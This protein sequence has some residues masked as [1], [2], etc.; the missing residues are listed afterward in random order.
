[1]TIKIPGIFLKKTN[2]LITWPYLTK[3][4][5]CTLLVITTHFGSVQFSCSVMSDSRQP[6]LP[7]HHQLL[8][9]TQ[10]HIHWVSDAT[11]PSL[12]V[13][14][15]SCLQS[16]SASGSF[17]MNQYFASRGQSIGVSA[18]APVLPMNTQ[19]WFPLG[20]TGWIS[21]QFKG[22]SRVFSN[23]AVQ[24]HQSFSAQLSL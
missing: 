3:F 2:C 18:S 8:E 6:G 16:F 15:S 9:F 1:M 4:S 22:L 21:S 23:T 20:W 13:P 14:F 19:D 17:Q 12:I 7:V 10:S 5:K 11:Q 24:N